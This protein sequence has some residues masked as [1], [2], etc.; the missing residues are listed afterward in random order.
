MYWPLFVLGYNAC[1]KAYQKEGDI[2]V[3]IVATLATWEFL[4]NKI[5]E[6]C[7]M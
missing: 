3:Y 1:T 5:Y 6:K 2:L 4:N 7:Y